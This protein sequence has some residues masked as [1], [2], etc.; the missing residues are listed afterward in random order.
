VA[1]IA[2]PD[3]RYDGNERFD[4]LTES[5]ES[6]TPAAE[7]IAAAQWQADRG[8]AVLPER[9]NRPGNITPGNIMIAHG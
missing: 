7:L 2:K 6:L 3:R 8:M 9:A 1:I 5:H 4:R